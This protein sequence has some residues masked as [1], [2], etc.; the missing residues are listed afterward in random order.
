MNSLKTYSDYFVEPRS[1]V[2]IMQRTWEMNI[3]FQGNEIDWGILCICY[4]LLCIVNI[5]N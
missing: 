1:D 2:K 3:N 4:F 5:P